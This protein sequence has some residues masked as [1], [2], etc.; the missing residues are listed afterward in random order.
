[1]NLNDCKKLALLL[2]LV[3]VSGCS[4]KEDFAM[5]LNG[6][7]R[8]KVDSLDRGVSEGWFQ[9][10]INRSDWQAIEVPGY[11][12]RYNLATYDGPGWYTTTLRIDE[13]SKNSVIFFAGVDDDAD[14]WLDGVKIGSHTGYSEPF[15]IALPPGLSW[16]F[17]AIASLKCTRRST[18]RC[19]PGQVRNG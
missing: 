6:T 7:W 9:K 12:D 14:V 8:F 16:S 4:R 17:P 1:M 15:T 19:Q 18:P 3:L 13:S 2:A 10:G 5:S 11:W